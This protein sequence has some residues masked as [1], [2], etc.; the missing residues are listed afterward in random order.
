MDKFVSM[1][2]LVA[3]VGKPIYLFTGDAARGSRLTRSTRRQRLTESG[4]QYYEQCRRMI[5]ASRS[6]RV[7]DNP[8]L[9]SNSFYCHR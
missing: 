5:K 6:G 8:L 3:V 7:G 9:D 2:I 4:R 1:E